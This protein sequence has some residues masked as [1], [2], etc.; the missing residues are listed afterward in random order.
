MQSAN[1]LVASP[2][3]PASSSCTAFN[4]V[5]A[6][7]DDSK[8]ETGMVLTAATVV[9]V[10]HASDDNA[11]VAMSIQPNSHDAGNVSATPTRASSCPVLPSLTS[12]PSFGTET[13]VATVAFHDES[14]VDDVAAADHTSVPAS[15]ETDLV[16]TAPR[17]PEHAV[18]RFVRLEVCSSLID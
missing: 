8:V 3:A 5:T 10:V 13:T 18:L 11:E 1:P 15:V 4:T 12:P 2:L 6:V 9:M 14:K 16:G 17:S 7:K